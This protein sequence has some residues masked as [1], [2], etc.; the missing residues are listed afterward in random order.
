[1][2]DSVKISIRYL[3]EI[4]NRRAKESAILLRDLKNAVTF[5]FLLIG[6][7]NTALG[8]FVF[9]SLVYATTSFGRYHY[10]AAA[11]V[12]HFI[13][14]TISYSNYRLFTV[15]DR[16][17]YWIGWRRAQL[18][19]W[20]TA[21]PGSLMLAP[22]VEILVGLKIESSQAPYIAGAMLLLLQVVLTVYSNIRYVFRRADQRRDSI[23]S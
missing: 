10:V 5:K 1:M 11:L 13:N 17:P 16:P 2:S 14:V 21:I 6:A 9:A 15:T 23:I 20:L 18:A 7:V 12:A 8:Y 19:Y 4:F 22:T 3:R